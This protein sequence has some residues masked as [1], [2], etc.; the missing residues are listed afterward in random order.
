MYARHA[1]LPLYPAISSELSVLS[2][3]PPAPRAART[4]HGRHDRA[5]E[6][7]APTAS[8]PRPSRPLMPWCQENPCPRHGLLLRKDGALVARDLWIDEERDVGD[9]LHQRIP[10]F[11]I[12]R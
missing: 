4:S 3:H 5:F 9:V 1:F 12:L 2:C 11:I 6:T 10:I 8:S 7:A